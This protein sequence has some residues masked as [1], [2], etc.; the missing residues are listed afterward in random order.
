[1]MAQLNFTI[2][3]KVNKEMPVKAQEYLLDEA[4]KV[5]YGESDIDFRNFKKQDLVGISKKISENVNK[6]LGGPLVDDVLI[7]E[8]NYLPK[9][10]ARGGKK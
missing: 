4:F 5:L 8:L 7:Q 10:Q 6:R 3:S 1:M 9:E 2:D